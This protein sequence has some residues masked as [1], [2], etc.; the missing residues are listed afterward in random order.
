VGKFTPSQ[1]KGERGCY[2]GL[3]N[4]R[5]PGYLEGIGGYE[6]VIGQIAGGVE[7]VYD[8]AT[9]ERQTFW[10]AGGGFTDSSGVGAYLN[11]GVVKGFRPDKDIIRDY[12]GPFLVLQGGVSFNHIP[13]PS[14]NKTL[15][16]QFSIWQS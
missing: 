13:I 14:K 3:K 12:A 15:S 10:Y 16:Q 5:G 2:F 1:I 9:F 7:T 6:G 4:Y 8:F 11:G